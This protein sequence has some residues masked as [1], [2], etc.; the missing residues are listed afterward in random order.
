MQSVRRNRIHLQ[1]E[2]HFQWPAFT[3]EDLR[4]F[5]GKRD[6][7]IRLLESR[8]GFARPRAEREADLFLAQFEDA[9]RR[10]A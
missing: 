5:D 6:S 10:A 3:P 7:L 2:A 9:L 1:N 8:Y 4:K